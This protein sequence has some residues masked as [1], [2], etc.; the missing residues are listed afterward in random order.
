MGSPPQEIKTPFEW[1]IRDLGVPAAGRRATAP[2]RRRKSATC[3][4]PNPKSTVQFYGQST[5]PPNVPHP[6]IRPF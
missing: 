5:Y 2:R 6:E 4:F 3:G 1:K